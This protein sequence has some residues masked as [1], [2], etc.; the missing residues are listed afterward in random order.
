MLTGP[1][2]TRTHRRYAWCVRVVRFSI[3]SRGDDD[4]DAAVLLVEEG[5]AV[6]GGVLDLDPVGDDPGRVDLAAFDPL[7]ERGEVAVDVGLA[8]FQGDPFIHQNFVGWASP[9]AA[10]QITS[11]GGAHP[12][13]TPTA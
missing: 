9:T 4:L 8:R 7:Q 12:T 5:L 2:S 6:G 10:L 1:A 3:G 11:V 13:G